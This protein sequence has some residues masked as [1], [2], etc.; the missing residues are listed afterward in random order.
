MP[1]GIANMLLFALLAEQCK[2][3]CDCKKDEFVVHMGDNTVTFCGSNDGLCCCD[4]SHWSIEEN[5]SSEEENESS[6]A[7][8]DTA[9]GNMEGLTKRQIK[10]A[11]LVR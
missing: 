6:Q 7:L 8:V 4:T 3:S 1:N 9:K 5:E 10:S 2:I 11:E